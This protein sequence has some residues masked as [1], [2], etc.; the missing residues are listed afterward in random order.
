LSSSFISCANATTIGCN[1][2]PF[3]AWIPSAENLYD[4]GSGYILLD[5]G[6]AATKYNLVG[7]N[8]AGAV[9]SRTNLTIGSTNRSAI[10]YDGSMFFRGTS[11]YPDFAEYDYIECLHE[12]GYTTTVETV[13]LSTRP[14]GS[15]GFTLLQ[16]YTSAK[17]QGLYWNGTFAFTGSA[18]TTPVYFGIFVQ[19]SSVRIKD[20]ANPLVTISQSGKTNVYPLSIGCQSGASGGGG[21]LFHNRRIADVL[22]FRGITPASVDTFLAKRYARVIAGTWQPYIPLEDLV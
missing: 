19:S 20:H 17:T 22:H 13:P 6:T 9:A 8:G 4:D 3:H 15:V 7:Y 1:I 10:L 14:S 16:A 12:T 11:N 21:T 2:L 18:I 5:S